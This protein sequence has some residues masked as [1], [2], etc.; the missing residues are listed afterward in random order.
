MSVLGRRVSVKAALMYFTPRLRLRDSGFVR[1]AKPS[2]DPCSDGERRPA[3]K[4]APALIEKGRV[5]S[6]CR[7]VESLEALSNQAVVIDH[8]CRVWQKDSAY[9]SP[10]FTPGDTMGYPVDEVVLPARLLDGGL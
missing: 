7:T 10:W 5:V 3:S 1:E 8:D 4:S 9:L 2:S 6:M